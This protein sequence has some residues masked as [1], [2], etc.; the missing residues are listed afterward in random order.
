[1]PEL[2]A[3]AVPE[4][5][6]SFLDLDEWA[7]GIPLQLEYDWFFLKEIEQYAVLVCA[8]R[9][10]LLLQL[11]GV[12]IVGL[13]ALRSNRVVLGVDLLLVGELAFAEKA[14]RNLREAGHLSDCWFAVHNPFV[15]LVSQLGGTL[16]KS[17]LLGRHLQPQTKVRLKLQL[18]RAVVHQE[19]LD[20]AKLPHVHVTKVEGGLLVSFGVYEEFR[21][22]DRCCVDIDGVLQQHR[23]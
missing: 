16:H 9:L 19:S 12:L 4:L 14:N 2:V 7:A 10:E 3:G 8:F 23:L 20:L 18:L 5:E 13:F 22:F 6:Y 11:L 17:K 1:M 21:V 15:L